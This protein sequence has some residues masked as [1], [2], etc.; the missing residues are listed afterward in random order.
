MK[1]YVAGS[2]H[3]EWKDMIFGGYVIVDDSG[4]IRYAR[5]S[6]LAQKAYVSK[7]NAGGRISATIGAIGL[8]LQL[9][10]GSTLN[11]FTVISDSNV[12]SELHN[13]YKSRGCTDLNIALRTN[14]KLKFV[15]A[16]DTNDIMFVDI[17]R[18]VAMNTPLQELQDVLL[19]PARV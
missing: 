2:A 6:I 5:R 7:G 9:P 10:E 4:A 12:G 8:L 19:P 11:E 1:I 17:A 15:K 16:T 18:A 14:K 3:P 13:F